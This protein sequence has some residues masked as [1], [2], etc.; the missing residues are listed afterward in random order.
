LWWRL[1]VP[2]VDRETILDQADVLVVDNSSLGW[3]FMALD[4]PVVWLDA[5]WYRQRVEHGLRFWRW[6]CAGLRVSGP[7]EIGEAV[8]RARA[9]DPP[10]AQLRA[11]ATREIY[12]FTDGSSTDRAVTAIMETICG[13]SL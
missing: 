7:G 10:R 2:W 9:D 6:A 5:P 11:M 12:S 1:D 4:R 8:D 13:R 3:E